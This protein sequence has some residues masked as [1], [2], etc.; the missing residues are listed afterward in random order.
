M[1]ADEISLVCR[2]GA[3]PPEGHV[4]PGWRAFR[5]E[6][7][8]DFGLIG[9][10]RDLTSALADAGIWVFAISTFDTDYLLVKDSQVAQAVA[11]LR[12]AGYRLSGLSETN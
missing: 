7:Q 4:E 1:T 9:I 5:V 2:A 10:L 12:G 3:E 11:A 6:A 8:L